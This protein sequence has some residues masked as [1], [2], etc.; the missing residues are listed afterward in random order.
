MGV[1]LDHTIVAARDPDA[2]AAFWAEVI[3]LEF[4]GKQGHFTVLRAGPTS[5]DLM[6]SDDEI[7]SRHFAFRIDEAEFDRVIGEIRRRGIPHWADPGRTRPNE[8]H[9]RHGGRGVYFTDPNGH[10]L[11]VLTEP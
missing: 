2:T 8:I 4:A 3:G 6:Q 1:I 11:E 9:H 5:I 10:F 7:S